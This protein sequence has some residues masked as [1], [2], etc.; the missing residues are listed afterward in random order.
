MNS[1]A[2]KTSTH[3]LFSKTK[4]AENEII[5]APIVDANSNV[6]EGI[7]NITNIIRNTID[8][9]HTIVP[10]KNFPKEREEFDLRSISL[11][12][13]KQKGSSKN[14]VPVQVNIKSLWQKKEHLEVNIVPWDTSLYPAED[15]LCPVCCLTRGL[16]FPDYCPS[17]EP[18]NFCRDERFPHTRGEC[19]NM[20]F[21]WNCSGA[22]YWKTCPDP[23]LNR[24]QK[25]LLQYGYTFKTVDRKLVITFKN[26]DQEARLEQVVVTRR[27]ALTKI[28]E[29]VKP[30]SQK[31]KGTYLVGYNIF[32]QMAIL[33]NMA[34]SA[35]MTGSVEMLFRNIRGIIDLRWLF[36]ST[37]ENKGLE[38]LCRSLELHRLSRNFNKQ[39]GELK[40]VDRAIKEILSSE[41]N[42]SVYEDVRLLCTNYSMKIVKTDL[43]LLSRK[44]IVA[45][46]ILFRLLR[47]S[48][49]DNEGDDEEDD[50]E[51]EIMKDY[52]KFRN[53]V[54]YHHIH[55]LDFPNNP[56]DE[57]ILSIKT[58]EVGGAKHLHALSLA[59]LKGVLCLSYEAI[60]PARFYQRIPEH[61]RS[62]CHICPDPRVRKPVLHTSDDCPTHEPC[63]I[64]PPGGRGH[65]KLACV[66][67]RCW[68]C[69]AEHNWKLCRDT[70]LTESQQ[71]LATVGYREADVDE[72]GQRRFTFTQDIE[73]IEVK[74]DCVREDRVYE[75]L[76]KKLES[77]KRDNR[78]VVICGYNVGE[79]LHDL[80]ECCQSSSGLQQEIL[81]CIHGVC[82]LLYFPEF[83]QGTWS[84]R[85]V[86]S[87]YFRRN[88]KLKETSD[89]AK[90]IAMI[91][92]EKRFDRSRRKVT[93]KFNKNLAVT[94]TYKMVIIIPAGEV[95]K[96][97]TM[98][99]LNYKPVTLDTPFSMPV[100]APIETVTVYVYI[101][102]MNY[103]IQTLEILAQRSKGTNPFFHQRAKID[104]EDKMTN[105]LRNL[106]ES[107]EI[108]GEHR[109]KVTLVTICPETFDVFKTN[110]ERVISSK[111]SKH[112]D[113]WVCVARELAFSN[114]FFTKLPPLGISFDKSLIS[115]IYNELLGKKA[116]GLVTK[117]LEQIH[118]KMTGLIEGLKG[119]VIFKPTLIKDFKTVF[120]RV[121]FKEEKFRDQ[122]DCRIVKCVHYKSL[123]GPLEESEKMEVFFNKVKASPTCQIVF[124][125][126]DDQALC[127][128]L[129][130]AFWNHDVF[131]RKTLGLASLKEVISYREPNL[132]GDVMD[133]LS[134]Y[135]KVDDD[136]ILKTM[137]D[138]FRALKFTVNDSKFDSVLLNSPRVNNLLVNSSIPMFSDR[139]VTIKIRNNIWRTGKNICDGRVLKTFWN[140]DS[141]QEIKLRINAFM[142]PYKEALVVPAQCSV[143]PKGKKIKIVVVNKSTQRMDS[144]GIN[145]DQDDCIFGMAEIVTK[146]NPDEVDTEGFETLR[147]ALYQRWPKRSR[148]KVVFEEMVSGF[149]RLGYK[150]YQDALASVLTKSKSVHKL[151]L[152]LHEFVVNDFVN[153]EEVAEIMFQKLYQDF[154]SEQKAKDKY[155]DFKTIKAKQFPIDWKISCSLDETDLEYSFQYE[156]TQVIEDEA[157]EEVQELIDL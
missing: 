43:K 148:K 16:H 95:P 5:F 57:F 30:I 120:F 7:T 65:T 134:Q 13:L 1:P 144:F 101:E 155:P 147:E 129:E 145:R 70:I 37:Q 68:N 138:A 77:C 131:E 49:K 102:H 12:C 82:D 44:Q 54:N 79:Q 42:L 10:Q 50:D 45:E 20:D 29:V 150:T 62:V 19:P 67:D 126:I 25:E 122:L 86:A 56:R 74:V 136:N 72:D 55:Q 88:A 80:M 104:K 143:I 41:L 78:K 99:K 38:G 124:V 14:L 90:S 125:G 106:I 130:S 89:I 100:N 115:R 35:E 27:E 11:R 111:F 84:L 6:Y 156:Q 117:Q 31:F 141:S 4:K 139:F 32:M 103:V 23:L 152:N 21:C 135:G 140:C 133:Y 153:C 132:R 118:Q 121:Q 146:K 98:S 93:V 116:S 110:F 17:L 107:E 112:F 151:W 36:P 8:Q 119:N 26:K 73:N 51:G 18:C 137:E 58:F 142:N 76:I 59:T 33:V 40:F 92:R 46:K 128:L 24:H 2:R 75:R 81:S 114:H 123:D 52:S 127:G 47:N 53:K 87:T 157:P 83:S 9:C 64:H 3:G 63:T 97:V 34:E 96:K 91:F 154:V 113:T 69:G 61:G 94:L 39:S 48:S 15:F 105:M 108:M 85:K 66:E 22:H 60:V 28:L 71:F 109:N 149:N